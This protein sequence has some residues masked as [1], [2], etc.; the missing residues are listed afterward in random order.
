MK[1]FHCREERSGAGTHRNFAISWVMSRLLLFLLVLTCGIPALTAGAGQFSSAATP[2]V[3]NVSRIAAAVDRR[4]NGLRTMRAD[5]R[6][7]YRGAGITRNESGVLQLKRP[8]KMRWD[9]RQPRPKFFISDGKTAYFYVPGEK[10][11]RKSPLKKIDDLKSPL[12]FLL[13]HT[14]LENELQGLSLA[15]DLNP[16]AAGNVILRGV[17]RNMADRVSQVVLEINSL[18]Q[19]ERLQLDELD[20]ATTEFTFTNLLENIAMPDGD[21]RFS[22]PPGVEVVEQF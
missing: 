8:G 22:A 17:P 12:R 6:E 1:P 3:P 15:V 11:V 4:Y 14:R 21:F 18:N 9:Y 10:Q 19:I 2:A 13:G 5:F 7:V 16:R 20:G